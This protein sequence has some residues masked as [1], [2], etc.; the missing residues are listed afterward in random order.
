MSAVLRIRRD[1]G[2]CIRAD[3]RRPHPFAAERVGFMSASCARLASGGVVILAIGYHPVED[4]DYLDDPSVGA[5][6]GSAAIRKALQIAYLGKLSMIHVHMHDHPGTPGFS[7]IDLRE[8]AK[9]MPDFFHVAP[10]LP[11]C[12]VV[13]SA[14]SATGLCWR[15]GRAKPTYLDA[16]AETG[17]PMRITRRP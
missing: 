1:L 4:G 10:K 12:A 3:L 6:M 2:D 14:D 11:H 15:P 8:S 7:G 16:I 13:L 5:M 9:F 17:A